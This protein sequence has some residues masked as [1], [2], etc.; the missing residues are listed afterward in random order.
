MVPLNRGTALYC[1]SN[2]DFP[3]FQIYFRRALSVNY[4]LIIAGDYRR[5]SYSTSSKASLLGYDITILFHSSIFILFLGP[6]VFPIPLQ[7]N[8]KTNK[9][10]SRNTKSYEIAYKRRTK[11]QTGWTNLYA[12]EG[13]DDVYNTDQHTKPTT[14]TASSL[15][16]KIPNNKR[17]I[18]KKSMEKIQKIKSLNKAIHFPSP[19]VSFSTHQHRGSFMLKSKQKSA[20]TTR[21]STST[22]M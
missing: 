4:S 5:L 19:S 15:I 10:Y 12:Q 14:A 8:T 20:S 2:R 21:T 18:S 17:K 3:A 16:Y 9:F 7:S 13:A 6:S 1:K 22:S 11:M